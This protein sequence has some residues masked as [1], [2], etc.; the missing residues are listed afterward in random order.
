M[1]V[2]D[3]IIRKMIGLENTQETRASDLDLLLTYLSNRVGDARRKVFKVDPVQLSQI[4]S[5][6]DLDNTLGQVADLLKNV[7]TVVADLR[8]N[9]REIEGLEYAAT[10]IR[11]NDLDSNEPAGAVIE[12][13]AK[14]AN[15]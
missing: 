2:Y 13:V 15:A 1:D 14:K 11:D 3:A 9:R 8:L 7:R 10:L 12:V 4:P 6:D 5:L